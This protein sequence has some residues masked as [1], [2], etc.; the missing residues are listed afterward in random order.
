MMAKT[1]PP[2]G[3]AAPAITM[4]RERPDCAARA[5]GRDYPPRRRRLGR[6]R[7]GFSGVLADLNPF[8]HICPRAPDGRDEQMFGAE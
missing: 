2:Q 6:R 4:K 5:K 3:R 8:G 1:F 7:S